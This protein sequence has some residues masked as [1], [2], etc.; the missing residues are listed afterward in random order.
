MNFVLCL[1]FFRLFGVFTACLLNDEEVCFLSTFQ[2]QSGSAP[3]G[4]HT[5]R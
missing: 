2:A 1:E 5:N 3:K 4:K